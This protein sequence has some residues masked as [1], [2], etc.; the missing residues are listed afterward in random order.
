MI[1]RPMRRLVGA[2]LWP[3]PRGAP[4]RLWRHRP[5]AGPIAPTPLAY[6]I[7]D[8]YLT[9]AISRASPTMAKCSAVAAAAGSPNA[10]TG[11]HG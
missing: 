4:T 8:F 1:S 6:P 2:G 9:D 5:S 10:K 3:V 11:T 7:A